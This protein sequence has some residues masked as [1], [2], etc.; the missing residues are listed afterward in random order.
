MPPLS[1]NSPDSPNLWL[2]D[3][4]VEHRSV[5]LL[6]TKSRC[7]ILRQWVVIARLWLQRVCTT[8]G[9]KANG[10]S[11]GSAFVRRTG[12]L[13]GCVNLADGCGATTEATWH[14]RPQT[15]GSQQRE[16]QSHC[17]GVGRQRRLSGSV[18][19]MPTRVKSLSAA[20]L[21]RPWPLKSGATGLSPACSPFRT[22]ILCRG[23][24]SY[25]EETGRKVSPQF[26]V[27]A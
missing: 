23:D 12:R 4:Y 22:T 13:K 1:S 14:H 7:H 25:A 2:F 24:R 6:L 19:C 26:V 21:S 15:M 17:R 18:S 8:R 16:G 11:D 5:S 3:G 9:R 10:Y 20:R 27:V